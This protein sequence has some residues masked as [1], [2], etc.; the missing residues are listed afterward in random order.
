[1]DQTACSVGALCYIDFKDPGEPVIEKI[2]FNPS[3]AGYTLC[4]TDTKGSH[5]DLTPDYAAVPAEMKAAAKVFGKEFLRDVPSE[6]IYNNL[7]KIRETAGDRAALRAIHF[8]EETKRAEAEAAALKDRDWDRFLGIFKKSADSS[9]KYLQNIYTC[10]DINNQN[11][12]IGIAV[13]E[14]FLDTGAYNPADL[15]GVVRV[16]GGGF[17]GTIQ[18]FVK[19]NYVSEYRTVMDKLFGEGSCQILNIR[20]YGAVQVI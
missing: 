3:L 8:T 7:N 10:R 19:N 4:I 2:D 15:K 5:A 11:V 18:A 16:H 13:S 9:Y 6:D 12:S 17:A 20:L 14:A 1:M